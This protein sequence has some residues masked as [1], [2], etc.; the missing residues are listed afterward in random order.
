MSAEAAL[1]TAPHTESLFAFI[2]RFFVEGGPFMYVTLLVFIVGI[3]IVIE[4]FIY[5]NVVQT[6]N[7]SMWK[8]LFPLMTQGKFKAAHEEAKQSSSAIARI[9]TYGLQRSAVSNNH[10]EIE[11][12]MEEGLMETIPSLERRT[13]YV[14]TFANI[15][16]LLGLLGTVMGMIDAFTAVATADPARKGELLSAS[17][18]V[19]MNNTALGLI[20]A[21]PLLLCFSY[22]QSKTTQLIDSMEMASVKFLNVFR[23]AKAQQEKQSQN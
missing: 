2:V 1:A 6:R 7:Q 21:I 13:H 19:A 15:A 12:A 20:A 5:L 23:Q 18:S 9:L 10:E 16:T 8:I 14:A 11:M 22:L 4:R 17:I 3:A